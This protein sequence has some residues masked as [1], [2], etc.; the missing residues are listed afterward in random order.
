MSRSSQGECLLS[1]HD[2]VRVG[3]GV[4]IQHGIQY[5]EHQLPLIIHEQVCGVDVLHERLNPQHVGPL[6]VDVVNCRLRAGS[7][8]IF[9]EVL[10]IESL[11]VRAAVAEDQ[12]GAEVGEVADG[13]EW[14]FFEKKFDDAA[15]LAAS[16]LRLD[17]NRVLQKFLTGVQSPVASVSAICAPDIGEEG[18]N[19]G[20]K[21]TR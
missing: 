21:E 4:L 14:I 8:L 10:N 12:S 6:D 1:H 16:C 11:G 15:E 7:F 13:S 18:W 19:E 20:M 17:F 3:F 5:V 2:T 9:G